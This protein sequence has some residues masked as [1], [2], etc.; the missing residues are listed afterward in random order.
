MLHFLG[1][2]TLLCTILC[3]LIAQYSA[4]YSAQYFAL[5]SAQYFARYTLH[6]TLQ[7]KGQSIYT[8]PETLQKSG[9]FLLC[10]MLQDEF[11]LQNKSIKINASLKVS[12]FNLEKIA[13]SGAKDKF[14]LFIIY[15]NVPN[16]VLCIVCLTCA[17][18]SVGQANKVSQKRQ[19]LDFQHETI[20]V[21]KMQCVE[22]FCLLG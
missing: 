11:P 22:N 19:K 8:L 13:N 17:L 18:Y 1:S 14:N 20:R 12:P 7:F 5:Y 16:C 10:T 3:R 4:T 15:L 9:L 6:I 2:Q 21:F